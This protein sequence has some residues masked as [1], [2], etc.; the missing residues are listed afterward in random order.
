MGLSIGRP[1]LL[2][3]SSSKHVL[4][5]NNSRT[6]KHFRILI[7]RHTY[8]H[9]VIT[10]HVEPFVCADNLRPLC[11]C[12][13]NGSQFIPGMNKCFHLTR[14]LTSIQQ[15]MFILYPHHLYV[16]LDHIRAIC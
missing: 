12:T 1:F 8:Y 13:H 14:C 7:V 15:E 11:S 2:T 16:M 4:T 6:R 5:K 9:H 3:V 10:L